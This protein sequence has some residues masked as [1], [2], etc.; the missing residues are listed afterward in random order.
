MTLDLLIRILYS[1]LATCGLKYVPPR[2]K[3]TINEPQP[4]VIRLLQPY[5]NFKAT[6]ARFRQARH[7]VVLGLFVG[8][9][10]I[11]ITPDRRPYY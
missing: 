5:S 10:V 7:S 3:E 6:I 9:R 8:K 1:Y 2:S 11:I 4:E